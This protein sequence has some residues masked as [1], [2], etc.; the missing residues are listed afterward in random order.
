MSIAPQAIHSNLSRP[1]PTDSRLLQNLIKGEKSYIDN[2]AS[3]SAS[4]YAAASAL[5]AWGTSEAPDIARASQALAEVLASVA[6]AERTH[7]QALE[8][9]RSALKDVLDREQSIRSVV[10]DRDI[11]VGRLIKASKKKV[12]KKDHGLSYDERN[13]K[14]LAAQRELHACEQVLASEEAALVGV[15]RR[16][17]KEALTM[18]MKTL[19][20]AGA[21]MVD[22]AK[23]AI[24]LLDEF[25]T[26]GPLLQASGGGQYES[27]YADEGVEHGE[28]DD[29]GAE[30]DFHAGGGEHGGHDHAAVNGSGLIPDGHG[31]FLKDVQ[32]H[33]EL[34]PRFSQ[35]FDI[36]SVTPSQSASQVV[37]NDRNAV[38]LGQR[39]TSQFN[40]VAEQEGT[41][42]DTDSEE[43]YRRAFIE[44]RMNLPAPHEFG[45]AAETQDSYI[46]QSAAAANASRSNTRKAK[47]G[48]S[49]R[50]PAGGP[51]PSLPAKDAMPSV[52]MPPVPS[53]PR[54]DVAQARNF[55][56][57]PTAP[58]PQTGRDD[59]TS[60]DETQPRRSSSN[61]GPRPGR[62]SYQGPGRGPANGSEDGISYSVKRSDSIFGKVGKLFKTD[63]RDPPS[64]ERESWDTRTDRLLQTQDNKRKGMI[65]RAEPDSSDEE[66]DPR[67][68][69]R[70]VN[71]SKPLWGRETN[72][73]VGMKGK[74]IR[75][76]S[77]SRIT[78]GPLSNRAQQEEDEKLA[79]IR[80]SVVGNGFAGQTSN[81]GIASGAAS[82][83]SSGTKTKKKKKKKPATAG[84]EIGTAPT[85]T[86]AS[87]V[88]AVPT[89]VVVPGDASA[90][91][92]HA[93]APAQPGLSRSSTLQSSA[94][95]KKKRTSVLASSG[96]E[97]GASSP[98]T[99]FTPYEGKYSTASWVGKP[100]SQMTA[101]EAVAMAGV[102]PK[103]PSSRPQSSSQ[104][105]PALD[106]GL[107]PSSRPASIRSS[108]SKTAPLKPS[109]KAPS[110]SRAT[111]NSSSFSP[112]KVTPTAP[113]Q[114]SSLRNETTPVQAPPPQPQ[115]APV[116]TAPAP[117][118]S[119][120]A[121]AEAV[122]AATKPAVSSGAAAQP[123]T[124]KPPVTTSAEAKATVSRPVPSLGKDDAI[125]GT[126]H[127]DLP[128]GRATSA[129]AG[130]QGGVAQSGS[131]VEPR[132][133]T[134]QSSKT[135][136]PK[137]DMPN[138]EPFK[139]DL[140]N[141]SR[142]E[143]QRRGSALTESSEPFMTPSA[144]ETYRAFVRADEANP[145]P[146]E[147]EVSKPAAAVTRVTDRK[148]S[149]QP[150]RVYGVG[151]PDIS[152]TSSEEGS[153]STHQPGHD[154][155]GSQGAVQAAQVQANASLADP[156]HRLDPVLT[157]LNA[158]SDLSDGVARR[159]STPSALSSRIAPPPAAPARVST[160]ADGP[161]D[162]GASRER[163]GWSTRI[164]DQPNDSSSDEE[165][166]D[167]DGYSLARKAF[168]SASKSWSE[169][170]GGK[171]SKSSKAASVRSKVS[172]SSKKKA[173]RPTAASVLAPAAT[174][175]D[176]ASVA[177]APASAQAPPSLFS[178]SAPPPLSQT[179][180]LAQGTSPQPQAQAQSQA[181]GTGAGGYMT[182]ADLPSSTS[183]SKP[184]MPPVPQAP[185][186]TGQSA[187]TVPAAP[188]PAA[189]SSSGGKA[190]GFFGK[191]KKFK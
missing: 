102:V 48:S 130:P 21:A 64:R 118:T 95:K 168:G 40:D 186:V 83:R 176:A 93:A 89:Q 8:G 119:T 71:N 174:G 87:A 39:Y 145:Q 50:A 184:V 59:D 115:M 107:Q 69:V 114:S 97:A 29:H 3:S 15:K 171:P 158:H 54:L 162:L 55:G 36:A 116:P 11:L 172:T 35:Q 77:V 141:L 27:M 38:P 165:A 58:P 125:D 104:R 60:D 129:E 22:A 4:A 136:M 101:A 80:A 112:K 98:L 167:D 140:E 65:R 24:L 41:P 173:K 82:V 7:V 111:S 57:I 185:G 151:A 68:L 164:R 110:L 70:H 123:A 124:I 182:S 25:D 100:A 17:F 88:P 74:F 159:K 67:T 183:E 62:V 131:T 133:A 52:P 19:G 42:S 10:R 28:Y 37:H 46:P 75:T 134:S 103:A 85:R 81:S 178:I 2:L 157:G 66:P 26:H 189:E 32:D 78:P 14:V 20:D 180:E 155:R 177:S 154:V 117:V 45:V 138:S 90:G 143:L 12:G 105:S 181:P 108:A 73:D 6:D 30:P 109:L 79:A 86:S 121:A 96:A 34:D 153:A 84:S 150:S 99:A 132:D 92:R 43:D 72:S 63:L 148:V 156:E 122:A 49:G 137:L 23:E 113:A 161:V 144:E 146:T 169:A 53:A 190:R 128:V 44:P 31:G 166:D 175:G 51:A 106:G 91:V 152:D 18:R 147:P 139:I 16:T 61:W 56:H 170:T 33:R 47:K 179:S 135:P 13:E 188:P 126:G 187:M 149:L 163:S 76:P 142:A 191:L 160:K 94:G 120:N 9:Y 1:H 127:L 5:A